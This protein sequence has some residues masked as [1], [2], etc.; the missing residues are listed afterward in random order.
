MIEQFYTGLDSNASDQTRA[1]LYTRAYLQLRLRL[2]GR[3]N[4]G[5]SAVDPFER[6]AKETIA[7][8]DQLTTS[9]ANL[10][11]LSHSN[12]EYE[13]RFRWQ[14]EHGGE[15]FPTEEDK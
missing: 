10:P 9:L 15:K 13:K 11:E 3:G 5:A 14:R 12:L 6:A 2:A 4:D 8:G 1:V 7:R